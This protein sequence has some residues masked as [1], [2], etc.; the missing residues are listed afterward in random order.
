MGPRTAADALGQLQQATP[1][2]IDA[3]LKTLGDKDG[4]VREVAADAAGS[5]PTSHTIRH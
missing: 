4:D 5:A 2:I 1:S 3:L